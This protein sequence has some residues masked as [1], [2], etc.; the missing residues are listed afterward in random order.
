MK[1]EPRPTFY[2]WINRPP[3][4]W[5]VLGPL[6]NDILMPRVVAS[7]NYHRCSGC[8]AHVAQPYDFHI[9]PTRLFANIRR[10]T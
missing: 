9:C 4:P 3:N 2:W 5:E 7:M 6:F 10:L 8:G 1:I